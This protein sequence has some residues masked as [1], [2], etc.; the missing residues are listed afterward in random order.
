MMQKSLS[1]FLFF[2]SLSAAAETCYQAEVGKKIDLAICK[3]V[4]VN[5]TVIDCQTASVLREVKVTAVPFCKAK[6]L[7]LT[8]Q[9]Q[10]TPLVLEA[11]ADSVRGTNYTITRVVP[12]NLVGPARAVA[13]HP[14]RTSAAASTVPTAAKEK[15]LD[16]AKV[17]EHSDS[18]SDQATIK[19]AATGE[20]APA[21][22]SGQIQAP[23]VDKMVNANTGTTVA[24]PV[25]VK[26][27][28]F[29]WVENQ[30]SKN[31]GY[32]G[33]SGVENFNSAPANSHQSFSSM[34][35]NLQFDFSKD[36]TNFTT[37]LEAGEIYG[38]EATSGG[39]QGGRKS[40]L[41]VRDVFLTHELNSSWNFKVGLMPISSDPNSFIIADHYSAG[42]LNYN[43]SDF[44]ASV[45]VAK[46]FGNKPGVTVA[47]AT[48][49]N[50]DQYLGASFQPTLGESAKLTAYV[51][52]R[53]FT[54]NVFNAT[55]GA[56]G[57][58]KAES[59]W[60]GATY[61]KAFGEVF[62]AQATGIYNAGKFAATDD[63][64]TDSYNAYLANLQL[65]ADF[66]DVGT[67]VLLQGLMT[68]GG[69]DS[70]DGATKA[71]IAG[72]R[73]G[74]S[75][76]DPGAAYLLTVATS[77]GADDAPGAPTES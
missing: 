62:S 64:F 73:K 48:Y 63:T 61:D 40:I 76:P 22:P 72:S 31:Y 43:V 39:V 56:A 7:Q 19:D 2:V 21:K 17:K 65:K 34:L 18:V 26:F 55:A 14:T 53:R 57:A 54:D 28:G 8:A 27:S 51:V 33:I 23:P 46:A 11:Q 6:P 68:S 9:Y 75:S 74:F 41:E 4:S 32:D 66:K 35:S 13:L 3:P 5:L 30:D 29:A 36:K 49:A 24:L 77:D 37:I 42:V 52:T 59:N 38:G 69:S 20:V 71:G 10:G 1:A 70:V 47:A 25:N 58:G 50:P 16:E 67:S 45:W 12:A 15:V 44:K 60:Y